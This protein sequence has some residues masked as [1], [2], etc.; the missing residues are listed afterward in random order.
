MEGPDDAPPEIGQKDEK[1]KGGKYRAQDG[2]RD[3]KRMGVR[4][5]LLLRGCGDDIP[6]AVRDLAVPGQIGLTVCRVAAGALLLAQNLPPK[7]GE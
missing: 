1:Q 3:A 7:R 2:K 6:A 5:Q 4:H